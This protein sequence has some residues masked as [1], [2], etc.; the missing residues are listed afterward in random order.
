MYVHVS[1]SD[2]EVVVQGWKE[3][4]PERAE[5][6]FKNILHQW[7]MDVHSE[8]SCSVLQHRNLQ[9]K[10]V[11]CRRWTGRER[12]DQEWID[13]GL[14]SWELMVSLSDPEV[15]KDIALMRR[16]YDYDTNTKENRRGNCDE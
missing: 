4:V 3:D 2:L 12:R 9:G 16:G 6:Q 8:I 14:A 13:S 7:G 11:T 15:Q 1:E 5:E 10:V